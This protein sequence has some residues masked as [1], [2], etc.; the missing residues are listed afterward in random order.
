VSGGADDEF[1]AELQ[2]RVYSDAERGEEL[3]DAAFTDYMRSVLTDAGELDDGETAMFHTEGAKGMSA[4][5]FAISDDGEIVDVLV[6]DYRPDASIRTTTKPQLAKQFAALDRFIAQ[7]EAL[8]S[9]LEESFPSWSMCSRL[10]DVPP[11]APGTPH[12]AHERTGQDAPS[13]REHTPP[14]KGHVPRLGHRPSL[15]PRKVRPAARAD[16]RRLR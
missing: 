13:T 7:T 12:A 6:T 1:L 14:G 16:H 3:Q 5:G 15:P 8:T 11:G 4:S 9:V 10:S 2:R